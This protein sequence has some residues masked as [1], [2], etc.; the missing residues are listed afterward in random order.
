MKHPAGAGSDRGNRVDFDSRSG[1]RIDPP[2]GT[3]FP[4]SLSVLQSHARLA[5]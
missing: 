1:P 2:C 4:K 3:L 5:T